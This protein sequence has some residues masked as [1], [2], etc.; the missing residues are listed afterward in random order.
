MGTPRNGLNRPA[1]NGQIRAASTIFA[2]LALRAGFLSAVADRF[3]LW[4]AVDT[5]NVAWGNSDAYSQYLRVLAPYFPAGL[6]DV[7][8]WGA[9]SGRSCS[10][11]CPVAGRDTALETALASTATLVVFASSM[12]IFSGFEA[13]LTASVF[14]AAAAA[15]LLALCPPGSDVV[16]IDQL[17]RPRRSQQKAAQ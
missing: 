10:R 5:N 15:L 2:R 3:G 6:L 16:S 13:S 14:S 17:R 1:A 8:A 12:F 11:C 7:A 9:T 4:R